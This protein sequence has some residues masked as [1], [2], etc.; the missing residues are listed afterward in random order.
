[1]PSI[2]RRSATGSRASRFATHVAGD[3]GQGCRCT[4]RGDYIPNFGAGN[5]VGDA[6]YLARNK[7]AQPF[8]FTLSHRIVA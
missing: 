7:A 6:I 8:Q 4:R 5:A 3:R 2:F 1:M